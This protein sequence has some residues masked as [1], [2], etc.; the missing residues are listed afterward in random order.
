MP[1]IVQSALNDFQM[2]KDI[3]I[4]H[5]EACLSP[6][7]VMG[8]MFFIVVCRSFCS[9]IVFQTFFVTVWRIDFKQTRMQFSNDALQ[10]KYEYL[11]FKS[12]T[13]NFINF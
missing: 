8:G 12:L 10:V 11:Y 6:L 2:I 4:P 1:K 9:L 7:P 3:N 13:I 5:H